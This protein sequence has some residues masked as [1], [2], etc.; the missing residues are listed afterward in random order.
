[1]PTPYVATSVSSSPFPICVNELREPN[2]ELRPN[3]AV[4]FLT[5]HSR[6]RPRGRPIAPPR[7]PQERCHA[8]L[9]RGAPCRIWN[10]FLGPRVTTHHRSSGQ[11]LYRSARQ[12][13]EPVDAIEPPHGVCHQADL[14]LDRGRRSERQLCEVQQTLD[15]DGV[16][17][18][19]DDCS[20]IRRSALRDPEL[21]AAHSD[22]VPESSHRSDPFEVAMSNLS[23][24]HHLNE[25]CID[26]RGF[27]GSSPASRQPPGRQ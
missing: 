20:R 18:R 22:S 26:V 11:L 19:P 6:G 21:S 7:G 12:R 27:S 24:A 2:A 14:R 1:M 25:Q 17:S 13:K 8:S 15:R 10:T 16:D 5:G 4:G 3:Q 23:M 9:A